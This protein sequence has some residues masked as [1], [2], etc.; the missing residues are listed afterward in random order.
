MS[1]LA[2]FIILLRSGENILTH[3]HTCVL[4][5]IH[6]APDSEERHTGSE[7]KL[8]TPVPKRSAWC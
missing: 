4:V 3:A 8:Q 6:F 2:P 5:G 7:W 1:V